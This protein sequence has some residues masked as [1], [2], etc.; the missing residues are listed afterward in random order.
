VKHNE[1]GITIGKGP[2]NVLLRENRFEDVPT[3]YDGEGL[4]GVLVLP[5][6]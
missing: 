4:G 1:L 6:P 2:T 5:R 3:P